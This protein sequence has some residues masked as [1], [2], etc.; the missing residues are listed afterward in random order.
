MPNIDL[1]DR[2]ILYE[3]DLNCRQSN[4]QI[5]K[6]VGLRKD[7]VAYRIKKML[8]DGIIRHFETEINTFKLGYDVFRI[9]IT[10][11]NVG[12]DKKNEIIQYFCKCK[13]AWAVISS[14]GE[15]DLSIV[16]WVKDNYEFYQFWEKTLD[17]Y[18]EYFA[19][20]TIS[21]YIQAISFKR[22]YFLQTDVEEQNRRLYDTTCGGT[23]VDIDEEDY[24]LL[25]LLALNARMP[26]I[27]LA[28]KLDCSSQ[29][30]S[31]RLN[32]LIKTNVIQG[33][34]VRADILKLD[35][36]DFKVD[37]FLKENRFKKPIV[38]YLEKQPY[39]ECLNVAVGWA[40]IEPEIVVP[41][42]DRLTEIL[43]NLDTKF[44]NTIRKQSFWSS[45]IIHKARWL[46]E[47][48]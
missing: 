26:L 47:L 42:M 6:K 24:R 21:A 37:I 44:P 43:E 8:D 7:V 38:E 46:P 32:N 12:Q 17:K 2:K 25:D 15:I 1:K 4:T 5:G 33:F 13:N 30:V 39:I 14:K 18:G 35:L 23:P 28:E 19:R 3:L 34:R 27:E 29:S 20:N 48:Y 31:Y 45:C 40:S 41:N 9:Y 22:T 36:K 16:L 10:F 11:Q